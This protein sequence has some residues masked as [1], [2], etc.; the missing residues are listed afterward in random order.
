MTKK[1]S[2]NVGSRGIATR[3]KTARGRKTSSTR[4]L[5]RQLNDPYVQQAK[6]EGYRSRA[7]YKLIEIDEK[8]QLLRSGTRVVDLGAAPGGWTQVAVNRTRS[9]DEAPLVVALDILPMEPM[10]GAVV[11]EGDMEA[12]EAPGRIINAAGDRVDCVLSDIAPNTTGHAPTDH[13][14]IVALCELAYELACDILAEGGSFVCKVRQGGT[15]QELLKDM[16]RRFANVNHV[17]PAASRKQSPET[18]VVA[19]GFNAAS[20]PE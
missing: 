13:L 10:A 17:K 3:V 5:Q 20:R 8:H 4:W 19:T 6:R 16:R 11:L 14:R 1:T 9:N 2:S 7:A 12:D 18:Y 15:E